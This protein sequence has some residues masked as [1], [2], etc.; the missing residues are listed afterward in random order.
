MKFDV[1]SFGSAVVD[2]FIRTNLSEKSNFISY[3]IGTKILIKDLKFDVGGGAT[4]TAVAFSRLGLKTGCICKI[5]DDEQGNDVLELLRKEKIKF[6]GTQIKA[7]T[8]YSVIL[9][10]KEKNRTILTYKGVNNEIGLEDIKK[11]KT[12]W[13]YLSSLLGKSFNIIRPPSSKYG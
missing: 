5:G 10:S 2:A 8:G 12:K 1:V 7:K 9:D 4:N 11:F 6:L 13:L 3:P